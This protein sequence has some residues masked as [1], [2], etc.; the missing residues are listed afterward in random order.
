VRFGEAL[1]TRHLTAGNG[2]HLMARLSP[3]GGHHVLT[4]DRAG[5]DETPPD[6]ATWRVHVL[7]FEFTMAQLLERSHKFASAL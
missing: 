5:T 3:H 1:R 6:S 7:A 4:G 2:H